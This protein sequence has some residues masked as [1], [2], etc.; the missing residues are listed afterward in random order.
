MSTERACDE[1]TV[2]VIASTTDSVSSSELSGE[3][4]IECFTPE[5]PPFAQMQA[6]Q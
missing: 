2:P 3:L 1:D 6:N 4:L 5:I